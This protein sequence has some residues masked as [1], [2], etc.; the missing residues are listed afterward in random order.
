MS[1]GRYGR[2]GLILVNLNQVLYNFGLGCGFL[3][4]NV[5]SVNDIGLFE[6][7]FYGIVT[8]GLDRVSA[9]TGH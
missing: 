6:T 9:P 3:Q 7:T 8:I 4:L 1:V 5:L 2:Y